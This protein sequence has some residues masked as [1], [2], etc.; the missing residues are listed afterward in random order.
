MAD[1]DKK[2]ATEVVDAFAEEVPELVN[3]PGKR[4]AFEGKLTKLLSGLG[5]NQ[6][7]LD[8]AIEAEA[9]TQQEQAG[10]EQAPGTDWA[11]KS[12]R[13]QTSENFRS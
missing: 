2:Q 12:K 1:D 6:K 3:T 9:E 8:A 10:Q 4:A 11:S 5:G 7:M 13:P